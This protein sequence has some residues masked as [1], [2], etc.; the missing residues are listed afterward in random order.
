M[1]YSFIKDRHSK[2]YKNFFRIVKRNLSFAKIVIKN[3]NYNKSLRKGYV[4]LWVYMQKVVYLH[5]IN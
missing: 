5:Q 1:N 3:Y 2:H 4:L